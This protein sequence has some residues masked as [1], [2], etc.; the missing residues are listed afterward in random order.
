M[1][2][3]TLA[4]LQEWV[5]KVSPFP[6]V[7]T[8]DI[9]NSNCVKVYTELVGDIESYAYLS[10]VHSEDSKVQLCLSCCTWDVSTRG[11]N[12]KTLLDKKFYKHF[13]LKENELNN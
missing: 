1:K 7:L 8:D 6:I 9:L 2:Q 10:R 5:N 11:I 3:L 13:Y 12:C 4:N